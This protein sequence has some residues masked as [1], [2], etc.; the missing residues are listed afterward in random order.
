MEEKQ[1]DLKSVKQKVLIRRLVDELSHQHPDFY[2][3]PTKEVAFAIKDYVKKE[4]KLT[5][6]EKALID[7]LSEDDI[8]IILSLN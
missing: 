2:Y 7:P 4:A 5:L 8:Q 3:L 6:D 1:Q